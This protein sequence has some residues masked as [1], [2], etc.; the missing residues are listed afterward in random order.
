MRAGENIYALE[1]SGASVGGRARWGVDT[2]PIHMTESAFPASRLTKSLDTHLLHTFESHFQPVC[3][4]L[5][6]LRS[7]LFVCISYFLLRG[8]IYFPSFANRRGFDNI[9]FYRHCFLISGR[10]RYASF[11]LCLLII[12]CY[13]N[14]PFTVNNV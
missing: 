5:P 14:S 2:T 8:K 4:L 6:F 13:S 9:P 11:L 12:V 1:K 3:F 10:A 7:K